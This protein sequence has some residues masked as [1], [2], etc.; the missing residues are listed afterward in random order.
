MNDDAYE[1]FSIYNQPTHLAPND[2]FI[3]KKKAKAKINQYSN[4]I[5]TSVSH[6]R[7]GQKKQIQFF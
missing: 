7:L 2:F 1:A 3:F 4:L 5:D 6:R